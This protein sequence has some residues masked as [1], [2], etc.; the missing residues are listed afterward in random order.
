MAQHIQR[1][2]YCETMGRE[3]PVIT[4]IHPNPMDQSCWLFQMAHMSTWYRCISIDMQI[5][6]PAGCGPRLSAGAT[7][8]FRPRCMIEFL[9][10]HGLFP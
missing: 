2:L 5:A 1:P 8:A 9:T 3:G 6:Y 10:N 7:L 4:F